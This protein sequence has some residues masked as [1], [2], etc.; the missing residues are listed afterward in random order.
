MKHLFKPILPSLLAI[1]LLSRCDIIDIPKDG[2]PAPT[3]PGSSTV[4][5]RVLLEDCTGPLCTYCPAAAVI[6]DGI[7]AYYNTAE[8]E[9]V[10]VVAINMF[11][12]FSAPQAPIGDGIFDTDF[13]TPAGNA[14][15]QYFA[16]PGLPSGLINRKPYQGSIPVGR[17]SWGSAVAQ[18]ID[19]PAD[20]DIWFDSFSFNSSTN[21][22]TT[23]VKVAVLNTITGPHN[24]TL[25]LTE[26][27]VIDWQLDQNATPQQVE[28]YDHRHVLRDN[29]NGTWGTSI[30]PSSGAQPGDTLSMSLNYTLPPAGAI[31]HVLNA[32]NCSLVA[33]VY[34][35]AGADKDEVKQVAEQKFVP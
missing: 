16:P 6:A 3:P 34:S 9:R 19:L 35:T 25:Y 27:H 11:A 12:I 14:Y 8:N 21:V 24:L 5:R 20:M 18:L 31:N 7:Q 33:Y 32:S 17:S 10:I 28:F 29:L 15:E 26:D 30:I 13:R 22:V 1:S 4:T 2:I 23:T